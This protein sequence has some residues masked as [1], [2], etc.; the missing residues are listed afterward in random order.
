MHLFESTL[1]V[2]AI[3]V[4]I[5]NGLVTL[6]IL[7]IAPL[8]LAAVIVNTLLVTLLSYLTSCMGDRVV[9][10]LKTGSF[11]PLP[12]NSHHRG[13]RQLERERTRR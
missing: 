2:K 11:R 4:A 8:G 13:Q 9:H 10:Y 5:V 6:V 1:Q 7:L 3:A 12:D